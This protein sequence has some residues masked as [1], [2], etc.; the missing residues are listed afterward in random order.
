MKKIILILLVLIT[1]NSSIAQ[2][3][4]NPELLWSVKRIGVIGISEDA[5]QIFYSVKIPNIENNN[6]D[7]TYYKLPINGGTAVKI[8]KDDVAVLDKNISA[9]GAFKLFHKAEHLEDVKAKDI[10]KNL[11]KADAYVFTDLDNRHWD[12]WSDGTYEHV[13]YKKVDTDDDTAIDIMPNEPYYSPQRPFGGDEDY[14][15]APDSKSIYYVSKKLKGKAYA[16]STNTD[17]YK[18]DIATKTTTNITEGN[19][20]YDTNPAFAKTGGLAWLQMKTDGYE[21]DKNDIIVLEHGVKQNLTQQW[22]G[23][24][25]SFTWSNDGSRLYFTAAVDGTIQL[26]TVNYPGKKRIAPR[27]QQLSEGEFDIR[28]IVAELDDKLI[29]TRGDMNHAS[30]IYEF[31]LKDKSFKQLSTVN[32]DFYNSLDLPKVEKR[33]VT[34]TDNKQMLVWV[35]LPPNFDATKKYPTLLYAQGG[36]QSP[37]SQFYSYRWNFQLMASQGYIIVAPNRRGMPG[38]GVAWNE[39]I[40]KDW[41]GQVMDDYLSAIDDVAKESYVDN[42]RL[43]AIGASYGGYSVFYLAGIH[44]KRFKS[45]IAHDGVFDTRSMAGTTEEL[46]FVNHDF[47]GN[48]WDK[49]NTT[50]QKAFNEFNPVTHVDKWDTPILIIQGGKDYRVPIEQGLAAFQAAQMRDIKSKLLYLPEENHWVLQPQNAL[51]WQHEFFKWLKETL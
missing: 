18:Y 24:V 31:Q 15:W 48:Y 14:I 45:F 35:I 25:N 43:G 16:T 42:D 51:V 50:A 33:Y 7:T 36:P 46:F 5:S 2:Q 4:M 37:L 17:I 38:H 12:T 22:D 27:V 32:D 8:E 1:S 6:F 41:G 30:E 39:A 26:F 49:S 3:V 44:N 34:T 40:S 10:Y 13:F 23:T 9:D 11:D 28:G 19:K 29:V 47:G 20:G 21:S